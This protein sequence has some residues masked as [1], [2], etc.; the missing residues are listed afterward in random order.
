MIEFSS[1]P[2]KTVLDD[3]THL[4]CEAFNA[5]D[6][7]ENWTF[8]TAKNYFT[9]STDDN[10]VYAFSYDDEKLVSFI[11]GGVDKEIDPH[12]FYLSQFAVS[13]KHQGIGNGKTIFREYLE[14][15][16]QLN[17]PSIIIRCRESNKTMCHLLEKNNFNIVKR[18]TSEFGGIQCG[19]LLFKKDL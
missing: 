6:K 10:S 14:H 11:F 8:K 2:T 3:I 13:N 18:Y 1:S 9:E 12:S 19:R 15:I 4:F 7:N 16:K 5:P 17:Y